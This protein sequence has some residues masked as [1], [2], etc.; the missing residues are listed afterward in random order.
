MEILL[1][2]LTWLEKSDSTNDFC[3]TT[4]WDIYCSKNKQ[5]KSLKSMQSNKLIK[6]QLELSKKTFINVY[7]KSGNRV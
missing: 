3:L 1:L 2:T 4:K 6:I 7:L 5:Q